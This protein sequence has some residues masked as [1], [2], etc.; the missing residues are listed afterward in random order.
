MVLSKSELGRLIKEARKLKSQKIGR[1]YTQTM[2][3]KDING[4]QGYIGDIETGRT[5]PT[6]KTLSKIAEACEVPFSFFGN[7]GEPESD[8]EPE[9]G[10]YDTPMI[11]DVREAMDLILSQ[12]TL[13]LNGDMLSDESK[14][15]LANAIKMG[16]AY[17]EQVQKREK[18][19]TKE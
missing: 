16:L 6:F 9:A 17:A 3:A 1:K 19:K 14:I 15:A 18:E 5:Y 2:L 10:T 4:S 11:T 8:K 7:Y 12:S 13:M